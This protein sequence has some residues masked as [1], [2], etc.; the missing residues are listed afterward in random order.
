VGTNLKIREHLFDHFIFH[1]YISWRPI[2][3]FACSSKFKICYVDKM[4]MLCYG[5]Y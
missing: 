2:C 1:C 4:E 5:I 3:N